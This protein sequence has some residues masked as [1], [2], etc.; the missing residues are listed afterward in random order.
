MYAVTLAHSQ[1]TPQWV[2]ETQSTPRTVEIDTN[3]V[4]FVDPLSVTISL[5]LSNSITRDD[6]TISVNVVV[7]KC[8]I[9][10]STSIAS[11]TNAEFKQIY[12]DSDVTLPVPAVTSNPPNCI[13]IASISG[14]SQFSEI[15]S[16][17]NNQI[18]ISGA[19]NYPNTRELAHQ[20]TATV[21]MDDTTSHSF[22]W[23]LGTLTWVSCHTLAYIS[24]PGTLTL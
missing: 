7:T 24:I 4:S 15:L 23:T 5:A 14:F 21:T 22:T 9:T 6:A 12:G 16:Y 2:S 20:L 11:F 8:T 10:G 18:V 3:H 13:A 1:T 17:N 19:H